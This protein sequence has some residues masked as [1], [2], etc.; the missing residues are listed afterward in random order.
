MGNFVSIDTGTVKKSSV[1]CVIKFKGTHPWNGKDY[2]GLRIHLQGTVVE[3]EYDDKY[4]RD[5]ELE[6]LFHE[7]EN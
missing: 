3:I 6:R 7:L 2:F 1:T 4:E 5:R